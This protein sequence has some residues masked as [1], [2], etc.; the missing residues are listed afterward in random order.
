M[1]ARSGKLAHRFINVLSGFVL[2]LLCV[3]IKGVFIKSYLHGFQEYFRQYKHKASH[4]GQNA[5][6]SLHE[7]SIRLN[8]K[9]ITRF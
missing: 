7:T 3:V 6:N 4:Y 1:I 8:N 2:N 9:Y 5:L